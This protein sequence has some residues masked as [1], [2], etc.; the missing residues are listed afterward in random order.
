[1]TDASV[2]SSISFNC[3]DYVLNDHHSIFWLRILHRMTRDWYSLSKWPTLASWVGLR[4]SS[5][6]NSLNVWKCHLR[7]LVVKFLRIYMELCLLPK[8]IIQLETRPL[9][10]NCT[11]FHV[12]S[13][14]KML[15]I[16]F[17]FEKFC[18]GLCTRMVKRAVSMPHHM[19]RSKMFLFEQFYGNWTT[20]MG[21]YLTPY[22]A[23]AISRLI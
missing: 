17:H 2:F 10:L 22:L 8:C 12:W 9:A 11:Q 3:S 18:Y 23:S 16:V 15:L 14:C 13:R 4:S 21:S 1:M 7:C 6:V 19:A 5:F 20:T